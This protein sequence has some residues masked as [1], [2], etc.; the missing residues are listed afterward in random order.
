MHWRRKWQPTPVFLPGESQGLGGGP[1]GLPSQGSHRVGHDW[2]NLAV[3]AAACGLN[4][5]LMMLFIHQLKDPCG[6][7]TKLRIQWWGRHSLCPLGAHRQAITEE[8]SS[9]RDK[10]RVLGKQNCWGTKFSF[11]GI[12][13]IYFYFFHCTYFL[14]TYQDIY[15]LSVLKYKHLESRYFICF[16]KWWL[17]CTLMD[18]W[19]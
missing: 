7:K 3:A 9:Y 2:S 15:Y 12:S 5:W 18:A 6:P 4:N 17:A 14:L 8:V 13:L 10:H 19:H 11:S 1:G 16:V